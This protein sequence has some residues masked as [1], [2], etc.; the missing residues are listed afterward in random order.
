MLEVEINPISLSEGNK[1]HVL[2]GF[3]SD[4][5]LFYA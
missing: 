5:F 1:Y 2:G 3:Q 4:V